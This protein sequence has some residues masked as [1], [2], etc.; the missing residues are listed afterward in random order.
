MITDF[1]GKVLL[2]AGVAYTYRNLKFENRLNVPSGIVVVLSSTTD[3]KNK[4][5]EIV[6]TLDIAIAI[7]LGQFCPRRKGAMKFTLC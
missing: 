7:F 1:A 6:Y 4:A 3:L 2:Q 5:N